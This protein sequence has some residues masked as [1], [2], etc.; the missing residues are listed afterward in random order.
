MRVSISRPHA[1]AAFGL[2]AVVLYLVLAVGAWALYPADFG[3]RGNW[4]SDLG[5]RDL[6]PGGAPFYRLAG[7]LGG[8]GLAGFFLL[9]DGRSWGRRRAVAVPAVLARACGTV[10]AACFLMTG[11]FSE[12]M[13]PWHGWFSIANFAAF[14]TAIGLT[15]VAGACGAALPRWLTALCFAAWGFDTAS[16]VLGETRWLEWVVVGLLIAFV[17]GLSI[18]G[19]RSARRAAEQR[20]APE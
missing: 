15:A 6:N 20:R 11:V 2:L 12:D 3:P 18:A 13:M 17:T 9:L 4:L 5:N 19:V 1:S 16:A 7:I 10:A 8:L 14:G